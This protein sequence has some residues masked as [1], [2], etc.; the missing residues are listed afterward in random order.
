M[1]CRTYSLNLAWYNSP[2]FSATVYKKKNDIDLGP[3][4]SLAFNA[5]QKVEH[6]HYTGLYTSVILWNEKHGS[7]V[8]PKAEH[9]VSF[10]PKENVHNIVVQLL[11][12]HTISE[13]C[14]RN[15]S[16][17]PFIWAWVWEQNTH[18]KPS[19]NVTLPLISKGKNTILYHFCQKTSWALWGT[20]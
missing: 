15:I 4:L 16:N 20:L 12:S 9:S 14:L 10:N 5:L 6:L 18:T 17:Y 11:I 2:W 19:R 1:Q 13:H 8:T 7:G 3:F